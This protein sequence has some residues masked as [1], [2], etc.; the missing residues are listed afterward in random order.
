MSILYTPPYI[1]VCVLIFIFICAGLIDLRNRKRFPVGRKSY[2]LKK[3]ASAI[4]ELE[5]T[6]Y[7]KREL[8][9]EKG[10]FD[11]YNYLIYEEPCK[12]NEITNLEIDGDI[13]TKDEVVSWCI[14]NVNS[15]ASWDIE[16]DRL[17]SK[18][19]RDSKGNPIHDWKSY[20]KSLENNR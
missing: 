5:E 11:T 6:G 19:W 14:K 16:Y 10:K 15:G 7:L 1:E 4:K 18:G 3:V 2:H 20:C 8:K 13:P 17:I 12:D 9:R